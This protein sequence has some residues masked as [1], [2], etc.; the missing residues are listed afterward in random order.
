MATRVADIPL[1]GPETPQRPTV[2][3]L[4]FDLGFVFAFAEVSRELIE[5]LYWSGAFQT[6]IL[7][8]AVLHVWMSTTWVTDRLDP[9]APAVQLLVGVSLLGT[10]ILAISLPEAFG[11]YGPVFAGV[12]VA[13]QVC[14]SL[15]L[16]LALRGHELHSVTVRAA[17][18][19]GT[20]ALLWIAG[21]FAHAST[22]GVLW[23]LAITVD[24]AGYAVGFRLPGPGRTPIWLPPMA[25]E[26]LVDRL[27][28]FFVVA[29]GE[30]IVVS[31][32]TVGQRGLTAGP[33]TEFVVSI[34]TT[35]VLLRIY[36]YRAGRLLPEAIAANP[37]ARL[38]LWTAYSHLVMIAA[39]IVIAVGVEL[40]I[41]HPSG[42]TAPAWALVILAGPALYL[43][44][45]TGFEYSVFS[46]VSLDLPIG[47]LALAALTPIALLVSP[48][49]AATAATAAL[50]GIA[51]VDA[52]RNRSRHP[53]EPP[54][55][56]PARPDRGG[57]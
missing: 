19:S 33:T 38:G 29:L 37:N 53:A 54:S 42:R 32:A 31:G 44:G 27:Q 20:S 30:L 12:Y 5:H 46:R 1:R 56:D 24:Y 49:L 35:A 4:F 9:L 7:L 55:P 6:L 23:T 28:Q 52:A 47:V 10:L 18:W 15:Y 34:V 48:L 57:D 13:V 21:A 40:V 39:I 16:V 8:L 2:L 45:R 43:I 51:I 17:W 36:I 14:R 22:R 11:K 3:E 41:A 25:P 26:H 50:A